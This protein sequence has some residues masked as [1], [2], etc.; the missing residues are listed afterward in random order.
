MLTSVGEIKQMDDW[1]KRIESHGQ[2]AV[3]LAN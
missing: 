3:F 2:T 1:A